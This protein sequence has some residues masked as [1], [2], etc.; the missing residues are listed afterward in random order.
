MT[1]SGETFRA[2]VAQHLQQFVAEHVAKLEVTDADVSD[3]FATLADF[4]SGGKR[5]RAELVLLGWRAGA[6]QDPAPIVSTGAAMEMLQ[7]CA[8]IHDDLI[9]RS[10]VRRGH[11]SVHRRMAS[12][13]TNRRWLGDPELFGGAAAVL[14][15]D[16][17]LC[18][19]DELFSSTR[20]TEAALGRARP[21]F[22]VMKS[23]LVAGQYLDILVQARGEADLDTALQVA[24]YKSGHYSVRRPLEI[25]AR[26]ATSDEAVI[27]GCE[28][29]GDEVGVAFQLRDDILGVFGDPAVTGKPAGDDLR[30]GKRTALVVQALELAAPRDA[31]RLEQALGSDALSPDRIKE[32]RHVI[33]DCGAL[34][35]VEAM[36]DDRVG[37][38]LDAL[39]QAPIPEDVTRDLVAMAT[40]LTSRAT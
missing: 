4:V 26:L 6:G 3:W 16:L 9:D 7:A 14:L 36:I 5:T 20:L 31:A 8:L 22:E 39:A 23:E 27:L 29:Y 18:W 30:E 34:D 32:L 17:A 1:T 12:A 15:G 25:G 33:Q 11:P 28:R 35:A 38:A 40:R 2:E 21:V 37:V 13:H 10:D 24:E 19:S